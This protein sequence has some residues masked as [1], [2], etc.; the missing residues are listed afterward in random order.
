MITGT[1]ARLENYQL[2]QC[3]G[4]EFLEGGSHKGDSRTG[5][6]GLGIKGKDEET[7][8]HSANSESL[9]FCS[10]RPLDTLLLNRFE[11]EIKIE[12]VAN[13]QQVRHH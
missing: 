11:S 4:L 5:G 10:Q 2:H 6:H 9:E 7:F 3:A 12:N 13:A 8:L 1:T